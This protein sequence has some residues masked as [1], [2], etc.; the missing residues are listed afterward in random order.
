MATTRMGSRQSS[1][2]IGRSIL[3]VAA[4]LVLNVVLSLGTDQ[5]FHELEVF[6]PWGQPMNDASDNLLALTYRSIY[7][8]LSCYVAARL[9]PRSPMK[10]ALSL[11]G[12]G[13]VLSLLGLYAS[14]DMDLGPVWYPVAL[15]VVSLPCA[16]VG[17]LLGKQAPR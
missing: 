4:G 1:A 3:A 17:G 5:I 2:I 13:L 16:S 6:P 14:L 8:V 11:G 12:I 9:A 7:A 10:H 15:A